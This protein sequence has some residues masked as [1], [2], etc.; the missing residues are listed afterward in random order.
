MQKFEDSFIRRKK[1]FYFK[2]IK[3]IN[4]ISK[5]SINNKCLFNY[6]N[7]LINNYS[8]LTGFIAH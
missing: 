2:G 3:D 5:N 7:S 6:T 4:K 8:G 1:E